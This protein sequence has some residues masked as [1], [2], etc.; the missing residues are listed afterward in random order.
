MICCISWPFLV[1]IEPGPIG[2]GEE[3]SLDALD[4]SG[5][6]SEA[7]DPIGSGE[8]AANAAWLASRVRSQ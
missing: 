4:A 7:P 5:D 2:S 3:A 8:A 1:S 6:V